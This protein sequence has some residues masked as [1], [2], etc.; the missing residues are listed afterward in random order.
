MAHQRYGG[1]QT[2]SLEKKMPRFGLKISHTLGFLLGHDRSGATWSCLYK[3]TE[4]CI[5]Q[6]LCPLKVW[7]WRGWDNEVDSFDL[8]LPNAVTWISNRLGIG[9]SEGVRSCRIEEDGVGC[10]YCEQMDLSHS[11]ETSHTGICLAHS[12]R[13]TFSRLYFMAFKGVFRFSSTFSQS[14]DW[15][16]C[17]SF[18]TANS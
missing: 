8:S 18:L 3:V 16:G 1:D 13:S 17:Y 10:D 14:Q 5:T 6:G 7:A 9:F 11:G 4:A 2:S 15:E 12:A